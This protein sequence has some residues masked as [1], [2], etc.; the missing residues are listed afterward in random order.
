MS[1]KKNSLSEIFSKAILVGL[2][3]SS[4]ALVFDGCRVEGCGSSDKTE[5]QKR[6]PYE[7]AALTAFGV[8]GLSRI[9]KD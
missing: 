6:I 7:A 3:A 1:L 2:I 4:S 9:L 8:A 5:S